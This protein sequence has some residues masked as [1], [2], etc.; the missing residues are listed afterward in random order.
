MIYYS[1]VNALTGAT[2]APSMPS[3]FLEC[4]SDEDMVMA[5]GEYAGATDLTNI[6]IT[7][8][9][10]ATKTVTPIYTVGNFY[11]DYQATFTVADFETSDLYTIA[12]LNNLDDTEAFW[13]YLFDSAVDFN[14]KR[15]KNLNIRKYWSRYF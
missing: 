5:I 15:F 3:T 4:K 12:L 1:A 7:G 10:Y 13:R 6:D 8:S 9:P 2:E 11:I 14:S